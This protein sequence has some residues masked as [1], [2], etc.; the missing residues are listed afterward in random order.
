MVVGTGDSPNILAFYQ[1]NGFKI[2]YRIENFF[3][4]H[5]NHPMF[6]DG[7]QLIDMV[8]LERCL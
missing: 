5:Y 2:S 7:V 3:I 4:D 8:Y 1:N 6:K